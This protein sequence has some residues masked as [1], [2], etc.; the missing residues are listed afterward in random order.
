MI[1]SAAAI[2]AHAN[3]MIRRL[4]EEAT[5]EVER[6]ALHVV[7]ERD[8]ME[9]GLNLAEKITLVGPMLTE[10]ATIRGTSAWEA[11]R[12]VVLLRNDLMHMKSRAE[13]EPDA[14][15]PFGRIMRGDASRAPEDAAAVIH[16]V[17]PD[18]IP[19]RVRADLGI[20]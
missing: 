12:R 8:S 11:Y 9:R 20:P 1:L 14:P 10:R 19:E 6:K 7:Y 18:W 2:E 16:A 3:D 5:V 17:E 15:G 13:N 4:P